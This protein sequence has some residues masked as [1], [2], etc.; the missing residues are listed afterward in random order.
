M[1]DLKT[2]SRDE[3]LS[4]NFESID[5]HI[6][7]SYYAVMAGY[8][9]A[10]KA[11][12]SSSEIFGLAKNYE[13]NINLLIKKIQQI[14]FEKLKGETDNFPLAIGMRCGISESTVRKIFKG[15]RSISAEFVAFICVGFHLS[16]DDAKALF[17]LLGYSLFIG[18]NLFDTLT[19]VAIRDKDD[20][21][22][23]ISDLK[24]A[25]VNLRIFSWGNSK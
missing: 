16:E 7:D 23:Y 1:I 22:D 13:E 10:G 9:P 8:G 3:L 14:C 12:M 19:F 17:D 5:A 2:M 15:T 24:K 18:K 11:R 21:E 25:G 6:A 4:I 20:I